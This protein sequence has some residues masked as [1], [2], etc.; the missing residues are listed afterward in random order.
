MSDTTNNNMSGFNLF[1]ETA[2]QKRE[3][4]ERKKN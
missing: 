1:G 3:K 4:E 2:Q